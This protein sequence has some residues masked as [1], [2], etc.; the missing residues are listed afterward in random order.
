MVMMFGFLSACEF[1]PGTE[2]YAIER[3]KRT[4]SISLIDPSA[5]QFREV[6]KRGDWVCG[7][8]NAKNRMG[9]FVGFKR[10]LVRMDT[11]EAQMDP[12]FSFTDLLGAQDSC[13][14]AT[15][16]SYSSVASTLSACE[17]ASEQKINQLLQVKF[18]GDW[19]ANCAQPRPK[20]VFRPVLGDPVTVEPAPVEA[21]PE[22]ESEAQSAPQTLPADNINVASESSPG[23]PDQSE[24]DRIFSTPPPVR[25]P[26][27][28]N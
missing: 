16:N 3:A 5:A 24:L 10:F 18:D 9:A 22:V 8:L 15:G 2:A 19:S 21:E 4:V 11:N 1:V 26:A 14:S 28:N 23:G 12:E 6:Q 27:S 20:S 25:P 17:R 13:R 7:E